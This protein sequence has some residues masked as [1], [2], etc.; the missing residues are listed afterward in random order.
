MKTSDKIIPNKIDDNVGI[1]SERLVINC[2]MPILSTYC[3]LHPNFS[4]SIQAQQYYI[5][6]IFYAVDFLYQFY[7][8]PP[9]YFSLLDNAVRT[10][11]KLASLGDREM[12]AEYYDKANVVFQTA[13]DKTRQDSIYKQIWSGKAREYNDKANT[14]RNATPDVS[15]EERIMQ[16]YS[17]FAESMP[18]EFIK[19]LLL[20]NYKRYESKCRLSESHSNIGLHHR[21]HRNQQDD[22]RAPLLYGLF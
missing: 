12:L 20:D 3:D 11:E 1:F 9:V 19:N 5:G 10:L 22:E 17:S 6:A 7:N 21:G 18:H 16:L 14:I 8:L 2:C 13:A 4:F 15:Y